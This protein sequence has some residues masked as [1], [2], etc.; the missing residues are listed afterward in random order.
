MWNNFEGVARTREQTLDRINTL[1]WTN[2]HPQGITLHN[3]AAPTLAQWAEEGPAHDARI[4]NLQ[5][6]YE[7]EKGWHAGPHFFVSRHW[8]NWFSN[9]LLPGVHSRCFN[10]THFGIEMVGDYATEEFDSG[11][12]ALVRDN[13]VFLVA[14]LNLRFGFDPDNLTFHID[15]KRDNHACPGDKVVKA[16]VIARVRAEM[17]SLGSR[18]PPK[19]VAVASSRMI[20]IVATEFGGEGDEQRVAYSD[21]QSGWA[22]RA[23][24]ALPTRFSGQRPKVRVFKGSKSCLCDIIDVGPWYP[25]ARG[26]EDRYWETGSRPRAELDDRTNRA[27]IDLTPAAANAISLNG[28][29]IVDWE[30]ADA[31]AHGKDTVTPQPE[32]G[33][34]ATEFEATIARINARLD[35]FE[36]RLAAS[37]PVSPAQS[38]LSDLLQQVMKIIQALKETPANPSAAAADAPE[39]QLRRIIELLKSGLGSVDP[40]RIADA[41]KTLG[42]VNGALGQW[43]GTLLDG[44]KSAIGIIGAAATAILQAVGPGMPLTSIA[45]ALGAGA[46]PGLGQVALPLFLAMTAWGILGKMEKW[47][48][49]SP[50]PGGAQLGKSGA[51]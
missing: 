9:P 21:V 30:F 29:G 20:N 36:T 24:V 10:A 31:V 16:D 8:I 15:C 4:R 17:D 13:A 25:S 7:N 47:A 33:P 39:E 32:S 51:S 34:M 50:A 23:G 37:P 22:N 2:W 49:N 18:S 35:A 11:D 6:Y 5:S 38:G 19:P 46:V 40:K 42:P 28:K 41:A 45:G 3:T 26:P 48:G 1:K 12:G 44:K 43:L 14:A 27:G